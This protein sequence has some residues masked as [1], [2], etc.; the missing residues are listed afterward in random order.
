MEVEDRYSGLVG[1]F[2]ESGDVDVL[3]H[4]EDGLKSGCLM[5]TLKTS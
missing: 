1:H 2:Q 4:C 5:V 3:K